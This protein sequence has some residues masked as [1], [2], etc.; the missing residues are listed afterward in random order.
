MSDIVTAKMDSPQPDAATERFTGNFRGVDVEYEVR[1]GLAIME[2]DIILG[3]A[4]EMRPAEGGK[5]RQKQAVG[6]TSSSFRWPGGKIP[7]AVDYTVPNQARITAAVNHWNTMLG[8]AIRFVP[9]TS[10]SVYLRIMRGSSCSAMIGMGWTNTMYLSDACAT[11]NVIHEL[12]HTVGLFHEHVREDRNQHVRIRTENILSSALSQFA[13]MSN[14]SD[15]IG[16]YDFNSIMHYS[17]YSW[18]ANGQVTIETIP[19]GI[20]IGQ[21]QALSTGDIAAVRRMY[22][23]GYTVPTTTTAPA[24]A[25]AP[26]PTPVATPVSVTISANPVSEQIIVDGTSYKGSV[27]LQWTVGS[28]HTVSAPNRPASNGSSATF[29]RWSDGGAATHTVTANSTATL[30]RADFSIMYSV[31]AGVSNAGGTVSLSPVASSGYHPA[32][33]SLTLTATPASGYCFGGWSGLI[34]G[35]PPK[36][37]LTVTKPYA[38]TANFAAASFSLSQQLVYVA[39]VANTYSVNVTATTGCSWTAQ[40]QTPWIHVST[41]TRSGSGTVSYTVDANASGVNRIGGIVIGG[42]AFYVIQYK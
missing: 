22:G 36:T 5:E 27:T 17:A 2:G 8:G 34:A 15:D 23:Y 31:T 10:E 30:Y 6:L 21:R 41:A 12:G 7:Y 18:T 20:P 40:S 1:D 32:N 37:T 42:R 14:V 3:P 29:V 28:T 9:R 26:A 24:P 35:T 4:H 39:A 38:V 25:P 11:G 19:A 13:Q 16:T 33:S